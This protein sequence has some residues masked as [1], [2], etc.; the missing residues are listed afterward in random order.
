MH[1]SY[2]TGEQTN[3]CAKTRFGMSQGAPTAAARLRIEIVMRGPAQRTGI[4]DAAVSE[5]MKLPFG[6]PLTA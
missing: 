5:P 3:A 2:A 4:A 1:P 6:S